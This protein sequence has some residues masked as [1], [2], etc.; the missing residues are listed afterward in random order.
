MGDGSVTREELNLKSNSSKWIHETFAD[1]QQFK[2]QEG[3][4]EFSVSESLVERVR[5]YI[6]GQEEHHLRKTFQEEFR[7]FLRAHRVEFDERY[8][9]D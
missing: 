8:L 2:W 7:E 1:L 9:W 4:A 3:Y 6:L 5:E